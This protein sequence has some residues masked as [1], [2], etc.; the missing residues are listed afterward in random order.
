[1]RMRW[2]MDL[3]PRNFNAPALQA[4]DI[5]IDLALAQLLKANA[6]IQSGRF[7]EAIGG[8][9]A[10]YRT[11]EVLAAERPL[12]FWDFLLAAANAFST[13]L[14]R[15]GNALRAREVIEEFLRG[16]EALAQNYPKAFAA[17]YVA[18]LITLS[19]ALGEFGDGTEAVRRAE[20][21]VAQA[22]RFRRA[23][24]ASASAL[25]G[26]ALNNLFLRMYDLGDFLKARDVASRAMRAFENAP[27]PLGQFEDEAIRAYRNLAE[28]LRMTGETPAEFRK[29]LRM[30]TKATA[31]AVERSASNQPAD[32][33]LL[34]QCYSSQSLC[35]WQVD[36][37]EAA[38]ASEKRSMAVRRRLFDAAPN[39]YRKDVAYSL[40]LLGTYYLDLGNSRDALR[41]LA[42]SIRE[43]RTLSGHSDEDISKYLA[44][45]FH[46]RCHILLAFQKPKPALR[47]L[48]AT[49]DLLLGAFHR[50]PD[51]VRARILE[52]L[53]IYKSLKERLRE[54]ID[55]DVI[56]WVAQEGGGQP[57]DSTSLAAIVASG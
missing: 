18:Y 42:E 39:T 23:I 40:R 52:L 14:A 54:E 45:A 43:Y 17:E 25:K 10:S 3:V 48:R 33:Q 47:S 24:G 41:L 21:A 28:S 53:P 13:A 6:W 57:G 12:Q 55:V 22:R 38:L 35:E 37:K 7:Q 29:A 2:Q 49:L 30:A 50:Q 26:Q 1:M 36:Q 5:R 56:D 16:F 15:L 20:A 32:L 4:Q 46:I 9:E 27:R 11:F 34:A 51:G 19:A 44:E 8:A 31:A